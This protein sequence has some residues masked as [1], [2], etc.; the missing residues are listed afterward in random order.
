MGAISLCLHE[1][2]L[3]SPPAGSTINGEPVEDLEVPWSCLAGGATYGYKLVT[4]KL[5]AKRHCTDWQGLDHINFVVAGEIE[6]PEGL[7]F[8][9]EEMEVNEDC[10]PACAGETVPDDLP[11]NF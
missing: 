5:L 8:R 7:A 2:H 4:Y 1:A 3:D 6:V 11:D 10:D 9:Y